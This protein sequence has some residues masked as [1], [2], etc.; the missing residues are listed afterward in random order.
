MDLNILLGDDYNVVNLG[1]PGAYVTHEIYE[2]AGWASLMAQEGYVCYIYDFCGGAP[3]TLSDMDFS[4]MSV[5]TEKSD[6]NA[7]MD[8]VEEKGER[9]SDH[10]RNERPDG[11]LHLFCGSTGNCIRRFRLPA[12]TDFWKA[13]C[14]RI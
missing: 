10:P 9:C 8:F 11:A 1:K 6:L 13:V 2:K 12:G 5:M 4:E 3:N 7:V 14:T